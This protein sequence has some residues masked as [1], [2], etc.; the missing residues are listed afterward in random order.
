MPKILYVGMFG[1]LWDEE[2]IAR[3]LE[4]NGATVDRISEKEFHYPLFEEM[5]RMN[6]YDYLIFAKLKIGAPHRKAVVE[7]AK[8]QGVFSVCLVPDLYWGLSREYR[9]RQDPIFQA[10]LV[11]TPDGGERNWG[12]VNHHVFRQAIPDE[13]CYEDTYG[14][15]YA[16]DVVF[17]GALNPEY[18]YRTELVR[19]IEKRYGEKFMWYGK[20]NPDEVRGHSLNKV[21][22]SAG[23][24]IGESVYAPHYWSNRIYETLGR[25]AFMVHPT[26]PGLKEEYEPYK[27][28]IP[29]HH[30]DFDGLFEII[31]YYHWHPDKRREIGHAAYEHTKQHHTQ[32][33]RCKQLLELL[34]STHN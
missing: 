22:A 4:A 18:P 2:G 27:H 19:N 5:M 9:I 32:S 6:G 1:K 11:L 8:K 29:Y 14:R 28:F 17:V 34:R 12:K 15:Q 20:A 33:V 21:Y 25:G 24:V 16:H 23:V 31:D 10:D 30:G 26:I 3:G 7:F 13:F